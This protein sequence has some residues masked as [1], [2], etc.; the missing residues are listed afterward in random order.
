MP[1]VIEK[2]NSHIPLLVILVKFKLASIKV[3]TCDYSGALTI[4]TEICSN[5]STK[6]WSNNNKPIGMYSDLLAE[7]DI[8]K[9]LLLIYLKP[10]KM[11]MDHS[12]TIEMYSCFQTNTNNRNNYLPISCIPADLFI[13]LQSFV[14]A[15]QSTDTKVVQLLQTELWP[16]FKDVNNYIVNLITHQLIHSSY[17]DELLTE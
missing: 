15:C 7:C 3:F 11:K 4:Y 1:I 2:Y 13:L 12:Q 10:T 6:I 17:S 8:S 14:M 5:L 16:H 9:L